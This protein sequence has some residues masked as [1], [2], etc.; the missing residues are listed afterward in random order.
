MGNKE[1][2]SMYNVMELYSM[3]FFKALL[4]YGS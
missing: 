4:I 2:K 1:D 3:S